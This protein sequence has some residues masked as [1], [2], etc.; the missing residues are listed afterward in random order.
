MLQD[1][2]TELP[3]FPPRIPS[4]FRE[5]TLLRRGGCGAGLGAGLP[6]S[7]PASERTATGRELKFSAAGRRG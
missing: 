2:L 3:L 5:P 4:P 6:A 1:P 7:E